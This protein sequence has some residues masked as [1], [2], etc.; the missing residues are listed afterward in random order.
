MDRINNFKNYFIDEVTFDLISIFL[1][2]RQNYNDSYFEDDNL[3]SVNILN[4]KPNQTVLNFLDNLLFGEKDPVLDSVTLKSYLLDPDEFDNIYEYID[5]MHKCMNFFYDDKNI[6][7]SIKYY[8]EALESLEK[9]YEALKFLNYIERK[10]VKLNLISSNYKRRKDIGES[11]RFFR[12]MLIC[13]LRNNYIKACKKFLNFHSQ[14]NPDNWHELLTNA[15]D[16]ISEEDNINYS[17]NY[18]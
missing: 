1:G 9:L 6:R 14:C 17:E 8:L 12:I 10:L 16:E 3:L 5:D 18:D 2:N 11:F 15:I 7:K 13:P 4:R